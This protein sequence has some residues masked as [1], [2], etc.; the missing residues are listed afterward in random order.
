MSLTSYNTLTTAR[1]T[2][3]TLGLTRVTAAADA[4][5]TA[6]LIRAAMQIDARRFQGRK[7]D[8]GQER[9][10]PRATG[11]GS[12][13]YP[14][15]GMLGT[16]DPCPGLVWDWDATTNAAVVPD[17]VKIAEVL[18]AEYLLGTPNTQR[19]QAIADGVQSQ[20]VGGQNES[21]RADAKAESLCVEAKQML[22][23]Y[24]LVSGPLL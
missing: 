17:Q 20:G 7:W 23:K 2:A 4:V 18:Q 6:A 3:T 21:Y 19:Q 14:S 12:I 9:E 5:L 10:F 8:A 1:A 15:P 11:H 13:A 22:A 16:I 24:Q